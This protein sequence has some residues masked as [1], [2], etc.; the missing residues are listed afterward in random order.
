MR[1]NTMDKPWLHEDLGAGNWVCA[2]IPPE[3]R[4]SWYLPT[5]KPWRQCILKRL[6]AILGTTGD[7]T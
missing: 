6:M 2:L 4:D 1:G 7:D 3:V 5:K